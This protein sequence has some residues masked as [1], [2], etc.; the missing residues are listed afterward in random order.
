MVLRTAVCVVVGLGLLLWSG[1]SHALLVAVDGGVAKPLAG[2]APP[3]AGGWLRPDGGLAV[4]GHDGAAPFLMDFASRRRWRLEPREQGAWALAGSQPPTSVSA[5]GPALAVSGPGVAPLGLPSELARL[6]VRTEEVT[7]QSGGVTLSGTLWLPSGA[8]PRAAVVLLHEEDAGTRRALEPYP[9]Y[10]VHQGL[11]VLTY[12]RRSTPEA[13]SLRA[14]ADDGLAAAR[15]LRER[16][17]V[18]EGRVG[19]MGFG[20]GAWVAVQAAARAPE[21]GFLVLISGGGGPVW[22]QAQ[23]QLR[24]DARRRGLT[25]PEQVDLTEFLS[26][27]HDPRLYAPEREEKALKTLD[28][29]L[30]RAK[31]KRW[32]SMTPLAKLDTLPLPRLLA[33][34]RQTWNDVLSYDSTEDLGRVRGPVLALFGEKD[35]VTP[36]RPAARA[37]SEGLLQR[38]GDAG[39]PP[40]TVKVLPGADH[41]LALP[42]DAKLPGVERTADDVFPILEAWLRELGG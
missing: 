6:P 4:A 11:A 34:Q 19:L 9:T 3:F 8:A 17:A 16:A 38:S 15:L 21:V 13:P 42:P 24:N 32:Y 5:R 26:M 18:R 40:V 30:K 31:R 1:E 35:E 29:Q 33:A 12:D 37:L 22:K 20:Q 14:L 28:F 27:L 10:L 23:H 7:F 36:A 39:A 41:R 25:G 2:G